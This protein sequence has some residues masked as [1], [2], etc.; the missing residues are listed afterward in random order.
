[1]DVALL[2]NFKTRLGIFLKKYSS[3]TVR[4]DLDAGLTEWSLLSRKL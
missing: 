4:Y 2:E 1:M 3:S